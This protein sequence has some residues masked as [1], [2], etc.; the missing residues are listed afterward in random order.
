MQLIRIKSFSP[1]AQFRKKRFTKPEINKI[2]PD[3]QAEK[4]SYKKIYTQESCIGKKRL[5]RWKSLCPQGR[6]VDKKS[7][8]HRLIEIANIGVHN[9]EERDPKNLLPRLTEQATVL[10]TTYHLKYNTPSTSHFQLNVPKNILAAKSSKLCHCFRL[11]GSLFM[12]HPYY[13]GAEEKSL[14]LPH[15]TETIA[16]HY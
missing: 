4:A 10:V 8:T 11:Q 12:L 9:R 6:N 16:G 13:H 7:H 15:L 5:I 1:Q 3:I 2:V 14:S